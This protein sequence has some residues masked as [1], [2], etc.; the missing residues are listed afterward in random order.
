MP[1]TIKLP[2]IK[3]PLPKNTVYILGAGAAG[4]VGYAWFTAGRTGDPAAPAEP[5]LPDPV[6]EPTDEP[7]F[8]VDGG[9]PPP[10]N[11]ADWT[12][13]A[14]N[15]LL[16]L[17][18]DGVAASSAIGKFLQRQRLNKVEADLV[19][20]ALAHAGLPPE[21]GPWTIL[22]ED[23]GV[24]APGLL[25]PS[26]FQAQG[27]PQSANLS[28]SPVAGAVGYQTR[29]VGLP[30]GTQ[31]NGTSQTVPFPIQPSAKEWTFEVRA[32][33][34]TNGVGP[35]ATAKATV[36]PS[37]GGGGG[38]RATLN[39]VGGGR[40]RTSITWKWNKVPGA[41]RY[42]IWRE[43]GGQKQKQTSVPASSVLWAAFGGSPAHRWTGLQPKHQY[44][45]TVVALDRNNREIS[46]R[47]RLVVS[48]L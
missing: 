12:A 46:N 41:S 43:L 20:Q 37:T 7:G 25:A 40:T 6:P 29:L 31:F 30:W 35:V 27:G 16:S 38:G 33:G 22:E 14:V 21:N 45:I 17:G 48:T 5:A 44:A 26:N 1:E 19:R 8:G 36:G 11:N 32:V 2:G 4:F 34:P 39:V 24:I 9:G 3:K 18:I 42:V 15:S 47:D 23:T 28:W 13:K 10:G